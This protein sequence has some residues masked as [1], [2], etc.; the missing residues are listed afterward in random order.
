MTQGSRIINAVGA[1][2][3]ADMD[4]TNPS[5]AGESAE[6]A[7]ILQSEWVQPD[8]LGVLELGPDYL[9]EEAEASIAN[10][11]S[12]L[13]EVAEPV[14]K[15]SILGWLIPSF[16]GLAIVA[17]TGFFGY[18]YWQQ[19]ISGAALSQWTAWTSEWAVPVL[20]VGVACLLA[21]RNSHAE[22]RRFGDTAAML[23]REAR[24]LEDRLT[25]VNRELSLAR[26]FLGTQSR[27]LDSLGR[28]AADRLT[29]H[30]GALEG[31]ISKN[32]D[33]IDS[34]ATVSNTALA[35][36]EKLRA[37]LPVIS[38]SAKDVS[39]QV[40]NAG[41]TAQEQLGKLVSGFE[42][43]NEF[44]SA[45]E[46]QVS[47]FDE[48]VSST[49]DTFE[50]QL[51][52]LNDAADERF[53]AL[54]ER[55]MSF[56]KELTSGETEAI[57]AMRNRTEKLRQ[58]V[59]AMRGTLAVEESKSIA[60]MRGN[61]E[62]LRKDAEAMSSALREQETA[63]LA[64]LDQAKERFFAGMKD[65]VER[66]NVLDQQAVGSARERVKA[67]HAEASEFD[68]RLRLRDAQISDEITKR[69][70]ALTAREAELIES[71]ATRLAELDSSLSERSE[72]QE[73]RTRRLAEQSE[74]ISGQVNELKGL[75][76]TV[77]E[78]AT[79]AESNLAGSLES[80]RGKVLDGEEHLNRTGKAVNDLTDASMRLME[81]IDSSAQHARDEFPK[82]ASLAA[83]AM[84]PVEDRAV[85]LSTTMDEAARRAERVSQYI[86][87][88]NDSIATTSEALDGLQHS[89]TEQSEAMLG[90]VNQLRDTLRMLDADGEKL[91]S[92]TTRELSGAMA[93][94]ETSIQAAFSTMEA[95]TNTKL[96]AVA[97]GLS[98][99]A[100]Q[101]IE[102][103][104]SERLYEV[105]A[106]I[107]A[108]AQTA[109]GASKQAAE[110]LKSQLEE[111]NTLAGNLEVRVANA[112]QQA[113]EQTGPDFMRRMALVMESLNSHAI[114][115]TGALSSDVSD[116]AW[117]SYMKGDR[118]IFTRRAVKLLDSGEAREIAALYQKDDDFRAHVNRYIH[119][120]ES[121]LATMLATSEGNALSVTMLG[122][123]IGKL[124][125]ALAQAIE[126]LRS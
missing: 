99:E 104:L 59:S 83:S 26:E 54:T 69:Q 16:A 10:A 68:E 78:S 87:T 114:D 15:S 96:G 36:M 13:E 43:L 73:A 74:I 75:F 32:S 57:E 33:K 11:Q 62:T 34:I 90:H 81:L 49:L 86:Q 88:T 55:S 100:A 79:A 67:L 14:V 102:T 51:S 82:A 118:G 52:R 21:L 31:L 30:A 47:S 125:V 37:D 25:V 123:D 66:I 41:R 39:N 112:R 105:L 48:K 126:R 110:Q 12:M 92:K 119:D 38:N 120:F 93:G 28:I 76:A 113:N 97:Q 27:E 72:A 80:F 19:M 70:D 5:K 46:R 64:G 56:R 17:W 6:D 60:A 4:S 108:R 24:E 77:A 50:A 29:T 117:A 85:M 22:A 45:S 8:P 2:I 106:R 65:V 63:T 23:S 98:Q 116:T 53:A 107:E 40:G 20:L 103:A 18:T 7:L 58:D 122:S 42:R 35:N 3:Q 124:Y 44:G 91:T 95:G 121:M 61:I 115:I 111:V 94:L 1:G 109:T 71:L 89:L 9:M 101:A 84:Q